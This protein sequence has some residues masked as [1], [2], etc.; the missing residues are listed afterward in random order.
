MAAQREAL[1]DGRY[2]RSAEERAN[3]KLKII[4]GTLGVALLGFVAWAGVHYVTKSDVSGQLVRF[5]TVS[6]TSVQAVL[7]IRKEKGDTG[8]CTVRSLGEDGAEVAR[9]DVTVDRRETHF[10]E[11]VTL[12]TTARARTTQLEGCRTAGS[13]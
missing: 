4:G 9:K 12:R 2:G 3:R 5:K 8:V 11:L 13:Q 10:T 7:E 6:P 1:P